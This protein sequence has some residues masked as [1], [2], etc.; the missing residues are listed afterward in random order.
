MLDKQPITSG[1]EELQEDDGF[2]PPSA[3]DQTSSGTE[4]EAEAELPSR[5]RRR[6]AGAV[7]T[8]LMSHHAQFP[9]KTLPIPLSLDDV[10]DANSNPDTSRQ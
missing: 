7:H 8:K 6:T 3:S 2:Q 10:A 4:Y 5:Q 9:F 1:S